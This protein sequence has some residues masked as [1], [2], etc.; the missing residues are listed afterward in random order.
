MHAKK[1]FAK[2]YKSVHASIQSLAV[3]SGLVAR[4]YYAT[5]N[6]SLLREAQ[7]VAAG[8]RQY[9]VDNA[10]GN[11]S[12]YLLRRNVHRIEKGLIMRPRRDSFAADYIEETVAVYAKALV[13]HKVSELRW[14]RDV[15]DQYFSLVSKSSQPI[16]K[17]WKRYIEVRGSEA[18]T[19]R[20][21]LHV[22][23]MRGQAPC[24][25]DYEA[26][27]ALSRR[28]RSVRWYESRVVPKELID[29]ALAVAAQA[30]SACNR[31]PFVFR[32]FHD[33]QQAARI[34]AI[35]M[36]TKGFAQQVPAVAVLVG[37]L[38]A[39]PFERDRHA[40][41]I[42]AALAG[43]SFMYAL[44]TLGLASCPIN[45]PDQQPHESR[46]AEALSLDRDERVIMLISIGYPLAEGMIP[47]SAKRELGQI[48][49]YG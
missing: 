15:L 47:Y 38:R 48:G 17:A 5:L 22:P 40:I 8:Q 43:M 1:S 11:A 37:Q 20:A 28:R 46:M 29:K 42:D 24:P 10:P 34:T 23:Y 39:Y 3:R 25:V 12:L 13:I 41:Y 7:A 26:F 27:F 14:A 19:G 18:E 33:P 4:I 9:R 6:G 32:I 36:G 49:I 45:W 44:E 31:Q 30:P 2:V 16:Y 35:P 21:D